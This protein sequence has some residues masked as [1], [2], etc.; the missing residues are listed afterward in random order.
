[1]WDKKVILLEKKLKLARE[2]ERINVELNPYLI[3]EEDTLFELIKSNMA[4]K[5]RV[6]EEEIMSRTRNADVIKAKREIAYI[7]KIEYNYTNGKI[8][9][10]MWYKQH[11]TI[12]NLI[13]KF[14]I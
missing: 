3:D 12:M 13:K 7:L 5:Y 9:K 8:A 11:W 10:L 2:L 14:N 4:I 6:W 1:M